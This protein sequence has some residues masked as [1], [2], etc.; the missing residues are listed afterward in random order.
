MA[1]DIPVNGTNYPFPTSND[2]DWGG[3]MVTWAQAVSA[4]VGGAT[5]VDRSQSV[6]IRDYGAVANDNTFDN[7]AAITAAL[8]TGRPVYVPPG[9]WYHQRP[10]HLQQSNQ[11]IFGD[12]RTSILGAKSFCGPQLRVGGVYA[13]VPFTTSL[14]T[15]TGNALDFRATYHPGSPINAIRYNLREFCQ[16]GFNGR[17]AFCVRFQ[18]KPNAGRS[19]DANLFSF[20]GRRSAAEGF[21]EA[22]HATCYP[23]GAVRVTC[24][25]A[26][27]S[28]SFL[29]GAGTITDGVSQHVAVDYDN[30]R[31]RVYVDG[32]QKGSILATGALVV[33]KYDEFSLGFMPS[34]SHWGA[35]NQA[36]AQGIIDSFEVAWASKYPSG[37][38]FTPPTAKHVQNASNT[39]ILINGDMGTDPTYLVVRGRDSAPHVPIYL[40]T[41]F[42]NSPDSRFAQSVSDIAFAGADLTGAILHTGTS[43]AVF[44]NIYMA[45]CQYGLFSRDI[46]VFSSVSDCTAELIGTKSDGEGGLAGFLWMG[47]CNACIMS[48]IVVNGDHCDQILAGNSSFDLYKYFGTSHGFVLGVYDDGSTFCDIGI[49][50][51]QCSDETF[52]TQSDEGYFFVS[53]AP[54]LN[55][56]GGTLD[57][58]QFPVPLFKIAGQGRVNL[59]GVHLQQHASS[60]KTFDFTSGY[61]P[62]KAQI[63][64]YNCPQRV[65]GTPITDANGA[66]RLVAD[67][68][69][70]GV[71]GISSTN[72]ASNNLAGTI[73]IAHGGT[74]GAVTFPV[75]EDDTNYRIALTTGPSGAAA[76]GS[77]R[78][79]WAT[80]TVNGFTVNLEVDPGGTASVIVDW[81]LIR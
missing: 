81:H 42:D 17:T 22:I 1:I 51:I 54:M 37:T 8:A 59:H 10:L 44:S 2:V 46:C 80:K 27:V 24:D 13:P 74:T 9:T 77:L 56:Y 30:V 15:G 49:Y 18:Y 33:K 12:G 72:I 21:H 43:Y 23:D 64:V 14:L 5:G 11:A 63:G 36:D 78:A 28:K 40:N 75:A 19:A 57:M 67:G 55:I 39:A 53:D 35:I 69:D 31:I 16:F 68:K 58:T 70:S 38:T 4:G 47:S 65:A 41:I 20:S 25:I 52:V 32:V 76:A 3:K 71:V 7:Y 45:G 26:G 48:N 6:D 62:L 50:G 79:S 66:V 34:Y 73:T 29:C 60:G 61:T